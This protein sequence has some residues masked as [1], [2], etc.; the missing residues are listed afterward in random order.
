MTPSTPIDI[1]TLRILDANLNRAREALR[2][3]EEHYRFTRDE[4]SPAALLKQ[5][6]H[7][8]QSLRQRIEQQV[9]PDQLLAARRTES[10]VGRDTKTSA[11]QS[12]DSNADV[13]K[14]A[15]GRLQEASRVVSEYGKLLAPAVA[16]QAEQLRYGAYELEQ[17]LELRTP[18]LSRMV[19][20]ALYVLITE[21]QCVRPWIETVDALLATELP[22]TLQLR[23][24]L[25]D[26]RQ[27]L[28]RAQLLRDR[29]TRSDTLLIINDRPDI[30]RLVHA[31]GIHLGQDDLPT[32][33]ARQI[34][35]GEMLIGRSTHNINQAQ[36][37]LTQPNATLDYLAVGPMFPSSTKP[38]SSIAGPETLREIR[39]ISAL[40]C[41]A[42][43]GITPDNA[44]TIRA[45]GADVL[46]V[47]SAV[48]S[49]PDPAQALLNF[50]QDRAADQST[51]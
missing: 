32:D 7:D 21:S 3:I 29:C 30:A 31:D 50:T 51:R 20:S 11:E 18:R 44:S 42:I 12:R 2:V 15:W 19:G 6:R 48:I 43:G 10:D 46:A 4:R 14:A 47:S 33:A 13:A 28:A 23:E 41:V 36:A 26:D 16:E 45:A 38:Q 35:G 22:L 9:G 24:K 1:R 8:L 49:S 40:P 17:Q 37:A 27:L 5:T 39:A 34:V 25:L